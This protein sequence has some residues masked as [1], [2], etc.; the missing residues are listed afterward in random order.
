MVAGDTAEFVRRVENV[1]R[2]VARLFVPPRVPGMNAVTMDV[3]EL[4]E[5]VA[6]VCC[7]FLA[8]A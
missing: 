8:L 3:E 2:V 5:V 4:V 7:V 1:S 6:V